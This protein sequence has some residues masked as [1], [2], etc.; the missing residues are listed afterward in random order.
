L[1]RSSAPGALGAGADTHGEEAW[2]TRRDTRTR[3]LDAAEELFARR[4]ISGTT[5]RAVTRGADANLA[6][7]H[8]HFGSKEGLLDAVIERRARPLNAER[9]GALA[10]LEHRAPPDVEAILTAFWLPGLRTL[11][12]SPRNAAILSR[13]VAR[14]EAQPAELVEQLYRR[15]FGAV[16]RRFLEACQRA[17][18]HLPA[19]VV[20]ERFRFAL[21]LLVHVLSG[22]SDLDTIPGHRA[23]GTD[24]EAKLREAVAF[25]AAGMTAPECV[26]RPETDDRR[27]LGSAA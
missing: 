21:G 1:N 8:Y 24:P 9:L 11:R 10:A 7:V 4:G 20:A 13:L 26:A 19:P 14:V 22:N 16:S 6:A 25:C 23:R 5:L 15:H 18:P 27:D 12:A 3:I 17:I 2:V